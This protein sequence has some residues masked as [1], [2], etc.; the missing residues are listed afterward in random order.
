MIEVSFMLAFSVLFL[1]VC[2]WE[3]MIFEFVSNKLY[4]LSDKIKKPLYDCPICMVPWWGS[5]IL[6]LYSLASGLWQP[7]YQWILELFAAAGIN[8]VLIYLI[9]SNREITKELKED[10]AD[11]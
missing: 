11:T 9:S 1:H 3:G 5:I 4:N 7:Y 10:E 8:T 6:T 2:T